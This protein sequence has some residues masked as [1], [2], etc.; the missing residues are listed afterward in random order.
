[1]ENQVLRLECQFA[2]NYL[3][4]SPAGIGVVLGNY[5][6]STS[7]KWAIDMASLL[8]SCRRVRPKTHK[9][10]PSIVLLICVHPRRVL[11]RE[12]ICEVDR[13]YVSAAAHYGQVRKSGEPYIVHP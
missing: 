5:S 1:M 8:L 13:A 11:T 3:H 4:I 12:Q 2:G 6:Y 7:V 10:A 9:G